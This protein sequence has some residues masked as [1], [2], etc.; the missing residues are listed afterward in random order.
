QYTMAADRQ[1]GPLAVLNDPWQ[2]AVLRLVQG[3]FDGPRAASPDAPKPVGVCGESAADPALAVVLVGLG[4][5]TLSM[6]SRALPGVAAVLRSISLEQARELAGL[7]L[8]ADSA[9]E[10]R[11]AVRTKL[12]VL[13]A[14][15]L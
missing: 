5:S 2:L 8:S 15:G 11:T 3:L 10:A 6:T 9:A 13:D 7:A 4:V 12:P 14:L 1:L